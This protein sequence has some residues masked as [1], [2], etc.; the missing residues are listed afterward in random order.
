MS[1]DKLTL[2]LVP[3]RSLR[4]FDNNAK[5]HD[6]G[7]I[8]A[9]IKRYGFKDPPKWEP[10]LNGE[11]GGIVDGNGRVEALQWM[12][13]TGWEMP[14]GLTR[15]SEKGWCVP[16]LFGVDAMTEDQARAYAIDANN[17]VIM[18]GEFT[19]LDASRLFER[20]TYLEELLTLADLGLLPVTVDGDDFDTLIKI[21]TDT[22][23]IEDEEE[24]PERVKKES[25]GD[26][27]KKPKHTCPNCQFQW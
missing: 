26:E 8:A 22:E 3:V 16:V 18:G 23:P 17:L 21:L 14:R 24:K 1:E 13:S 2:R 4:L 12:E 25:A 7:A 9:S 15:D 27:D 10:A 11:E 6:L 19:A 5:K 20:D